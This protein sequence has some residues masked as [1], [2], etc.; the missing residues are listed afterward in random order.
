MSCL[1]LAAPVLTQPGFSSLIP[2]ELQQAKDHHN[3][4]KPT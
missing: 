3:S 4:S 1:C 2:K